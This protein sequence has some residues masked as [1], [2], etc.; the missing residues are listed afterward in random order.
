ME[1]VLVK[2]SNGEEFIG[3]SRDR[4]SFKEETEL[5]KPCRHVVTGQGPVMIM[6]PCDTV[7]FP[8]SHVMFQGPVVKEVASA[9][10][11][12]VSD[13]ALPMNNGSIVLPKAARH[14]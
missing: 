4:E 7:V 12:I 1:V 14:G 10:T 9:Y 11:Q 6:Y 2:L 13:L 3:Q 8:N 5:Y